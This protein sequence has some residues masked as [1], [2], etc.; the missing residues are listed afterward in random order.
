VRRVSRRRYAGGATAN[1]TKAQALDL[2][3]AMADHAL[4]TGQAV[5]LIHVIDTPVVPH[6]WLLCHVGGVR[7]G[8]SVT[9]E[10]PQGRILYCHRL[11][12]EAPL[13]RRGRT[14]V[15]PVLFLPHP[16]LCALPAVL[17]T[18]C[19]VHLVMHAVPEATA[20]PGPHHAF[21][22]LL[23]TM[24]VL[25]LLRQR[26]MHVDQASTRPA[27]PRPAPQS[28]GAIMRMLHLLPLHTMH[29]APGNM[30]P[31]DQHHAPRY[32]RATTPVL[33]QQH[34]L[35]MRAVLDTIPEQVQHH[36]PPCRLATTI[37]ILLGIRIIHV[38]LEHTLLVVLQAVPW[39]LLVTITPT[40]HGIRI[41]HVVRVLTP[42]AVLLAAPVFPRDTM[43]MPGLLRLV[44]ML[45]GLDHIRPE[46]PHHA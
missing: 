26:T 41:I 24:L 7:P 14:L 44:I 45:V 34:R 37:P 20:V 1:V 43:L 38:V 12:A 22:S 8:E 46:A 18:T 35:T 13:V 9:R 27:V 39:C 36:V 33:R 2:R 3:P 10:I 11:A 32:P 42:L 23:D 25:H 4:G 28:P 21:L 5:L 40:R 19:R 15:V 31:L 29:V 30:H 16:Q 17:G 6:V